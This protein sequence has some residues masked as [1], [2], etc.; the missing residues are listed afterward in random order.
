MGRLYFLPSCNSSRAK[1]L[2]KKKKENLIHNF[3]FEMAT[4]YLEILLGIFLLT[5]SKVA[6]KC[7]SCNESPEDKADCAYTPSLL[8]LTSKKF[9]SGDIH[10]RERQ[11]NWKRPIGRAEILFYMFYITFGGISI[12][13]GSIS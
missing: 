1:I 12:K 13:K 5:L 10:W 4:I 2:K 9:S 6:R 8:F 11:I 3:L 7:K